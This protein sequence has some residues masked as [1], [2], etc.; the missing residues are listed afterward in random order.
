MKLEIRKELKGS[1]AIVTISI[2]EAEIGNYLK[3]VESFG[4]EF[5]NI[6]GEIKDSDDETVL[7][8]LSDWYI[9]VT[10]IIENPITTT[11]QITQYGDNTVKVADKWV[12]DVTDKIDKYVEELSEKVDDFSGTTIIDI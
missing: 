7:A 12:K 6:G 1:S 9:K 3:A 11:F 5:I 2:L 4:E 8:S 10:E